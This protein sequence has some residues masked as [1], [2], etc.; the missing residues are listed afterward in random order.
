MCLTDFRNLKWNNKPSLWLTCKCE[1]NYLVWSQPF[2]FHQYIHSG[3]CVKMWTPRSWT[4]CNHHWPFS[5]TDARHPQFD[6]QYVLKKNW[7]H[8]VLIMIFLTT[9]PQVAL[10]I[11]YFSHPITITAFHLISTQPNNY[12]LQTATTNTQEGQLEHCW[13]TSEEENNSLACWS[14]TVIL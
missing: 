10:D 11:E 3:P 9:T 5:C 2:S 8:S 1:L 4:K 14:A 7:P 13:S 12:H 6:L